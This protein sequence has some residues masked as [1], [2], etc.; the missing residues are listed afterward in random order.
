VKK[1]PFFLC[2]TK[3]N[4][5]GSGSSV[6]TKSSCKMSEREDRSVKGMAAPEVKKACDTPAYG[7]GGSNTYE[8]AG[9]SDPEAD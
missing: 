7:H 8:G 5:M 6:G 1:E 2:L 9:R 3:Q 4:R